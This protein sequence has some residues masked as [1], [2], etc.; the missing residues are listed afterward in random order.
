MNRRWARGEGVWLYDEDGNRFLD[1]YAQFGAV[2]FGHNAPMVRD[3][4]RN[5][6]ERFEPAMVQPYRAP[7]AVALAD[8]LI[9][10]C[11][12]PLAHCIFTTSGAETVEAAIKLV[13]LATGRP[14]IA[15]TH[16]AYHGKSFGAMAVSGEQVHRE[17]YR[18][19]PEGFVQVPFGDAD[20][21][22]TLLQR[23]LGRV[24]AF[25]LE[26]IQGENGVRV[27]P[28]GYLTRVRALC[29]QHDV[30][31]VL[32]EIQTGLGRT[33]R[34]FACEHEGVA[35]DVLLLSKALGGGMFS[36]GACL[37]SSAL[38]DSRFALTHSSTF[39]NNNLACAVGHAVL[40][41]LT[42]ERCEEVS[43]RGEQLMRGLRELAARYPGIIR[44]VRGRG[45]LT[46]IELDVNT[47]GRGALLSY[48]HF[49]GLFTYAMASTLADR[50]SI[51]VLPTL[52]ATNV[53]RVTPP[54][55]IDEEQIAYLLGGFDRVLDEIERDDATG[56]ARALG[57]L[58]RDPKRLH[59]GTGREQAP[60]PFPFHGTTSPRRPNEECFA[61]VAHYTR[62]EDIIVTD[63]SLGQ[64]DAVELER[65][66]R[67]IAHLPPGVTVELAQLRSPRTNAMAR[68]WI[69]S[70][71]MLPREM[72]RR[73]RDHVCGEIVRAVELGV[74]LGARVVGLGAFTTPYSD[75]GNAVADRAPLVTTGNTLTAGMAH[76]ALLHA[77][78]RRGAMIS[79]L[80][81]GVVGAR[82]SIGS[83]CA[84]L[85]A[86]ERPRRLVLAGNPAKDPEHLMGLQ[87]ELSALSGRQVVCADTPAA[88]VDCDVIITAT[89]A[90]GPALRGVP[91]RPGT[92]IV[93]L[94]RPSDVDDALRLRPDITVIEGGLVSLPDPTFQV[95]LGN[96]QGFRDGIQLACLS[97]TMLLA[98]AGVQ[99]HRGLGER[100][101]LDEIDEIMELAAQHGFELAHAP[102]ESLA[103]QPTFGLASGQEK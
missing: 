66:Q 23:E 52:G 25:F 56:L 2:V 37:I 16:G 60:K 83:A 103:I 44:E 3:A 101:S 82:G 26:P 24:G 20:A 85:V 29:D 46:G 38:W 79:D 58:D 88:V 53:L 5:V 30:A 57:E 72:F 48:L 65:Y 71:G 47:E 77:L 22:E 33:G 86:R 76:A 70:L 6:L 42:P 7:R 36:L 39:A 94:A 97:E 40:L 73:G 50:Q 49:A 27:P 34:L 69:I 102:I 35:P 96:L 61:F 63:P 64:L 78:E 8:A 89:G 93:D 74:S 91:C 95:G 18:P 87:H 41:S 99:G 19:L 13:R 100:I 54:L 17:L 15:S 12:D 45:L 55:V 14:L 31:L 81:V 90:M 92:I 98:M 68:G 10:R 21:F 11:P 1:A 4:V 67:Y 59:A 51:L 28:A 80:Q 84:R 62:P 9:E 32:D 43:R 75:H